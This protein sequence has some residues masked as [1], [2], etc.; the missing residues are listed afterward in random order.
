MFGLKA[1]QF[2]KC[3][4]AAGPMVYIPLAKASMLPSTTT[5]GARIAA[6]Q[7]A[8]ILAAASAQASHKGML[9]GSFN[10]CVWC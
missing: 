9:S 2:E 7:R 4:N 5:T 8:P 10:L 6:A 1:H 3:F